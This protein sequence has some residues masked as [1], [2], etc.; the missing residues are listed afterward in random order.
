MHFQISRS[1]IHTD[2]PSHP[3]SLK[4]TASTLDG[5]MTDQKP[6]NLAA[7]GHASS[8][9][10]NAQMGRLASAVS[11]A[12]PFQSSIAKAITARRQKGQTIPKLVGILATPSPPSVAYAQWT[13]KAC[14]QVGIEFEIWQTWSENDRKENAMD[15]VEEQ[16][17]QQ[18]PNSD[19]EADVEDL[20]IAANSNES[21][22]GIMV[23][24]PIFGGR[25]DTYLQQIVDPRK[26]VEGLH[27]S[28]CF[29]MYHNIRW[30]NPSQLGGA[31]GTTIEASSG[32]ADKEESIPP[33]Y[34]KSILPCTPLA[35]VKCLESLGVYDKSL[36]Y[37]DR[38]Y[39]KTI[40][41]VNRSE[42]VGRPLAALLSNDG[43]QVYSVDLDSVQEFNKRA[44]HE[45]DRKPSKTVLKARE[46]NASHRLRPS[47]VVR[48]C[49][50]NLQ[51]C[52]AASDVVI[53]GV[54]AASF[55]IQ[56]EWVK[57]GTV[58]VNFSS[59]K[60]FEKDV[61][62]RASIHLPAIGKTT[63]AMLQRNLLRL[64]E[65]RELGLSES[66]NTVQDSGH[67]GSAPPPN[68]QS[69]E[70]NGGHQGSSNHNPLS[71]R[72]G[73]GSKNGFSGDRQKPNGN[74]ASQNHQDDVE[75]DEDGVQRSDQLKQQSV[76]RAQSSG[77][78]L[79]PP[80]PPPG[81]HQQSHYPSLPPHLGSTNALHLQ[82]ERA[83]TLSTMRPDRAQ[84][85]PNGPLRSLPQHGAQSNPNAWEWRSPS[86][87]PDGL[88]RS[89]ASA[90]SPPFG[91]MK[92]APSASEQSPLLFAP[93]G[94]QQGQIGSQQ[95]SSQGS[96]IPIQHR[97]SFR[98]SSISSPRSE[99]PVSP[100]I[101]DGLSVE[102]T[103]T[104]SNA[105]GGS[106]RM[107]WDSGTPHTPHDMMEMNLPLSAGS[108]NSG[109]ASNNMPSVLGRP[110][111]SE[112]MGY[113]HGHQPRYPHHHGDHPGFAHGPN[114]T[115][116]PTDEKVTLDM[117]GR[118]HPM[119]VYGSPYV[120]QMNH[121]GQLTSQQPSQMQ[122]RPMMIMP[123]DR[124]AHSRRR[125]RPPFSYSS[126]IAQA[127]ASA[128]EGRMTLREIYTWI[129]NAYPDLYSMEGSEGSGW[130][131]TV[132]HNLSLNKAFIKVART[133]QDIYDSCSSGLPNLS[134]QAR[135]KGGWWMLDPN[136][137]P[138]TIGATG[139]EEE[140]YMGAPDTIRTQ[141]RRRTN[142][143][144]ASVAS[145]DGMGSTGDLLSPVG[146]YPSAQLHPHGQGLPGA[147]SVLQMRGRAY[148]T[149]AAP[150]DEM[151]AGS[152]PSVLARPR[153]A[154]RSASNE[155]LNAQSD[156]GT[157]IAS[158][159]VGHIDD[160]DVA[161]HLIGRTRPRGYTTNSA[162]VNLKGGYPVHVNTQHQMHA[163][164]N[165]SLPTS[166]YGHGPQQLSRSP[167]MQGN[168]QLLSSSGP[169]SSARIG[170]S[171]AMHSVRSLGPAPNSGH[172]QLQEKQPLTPGQ[173]PSPS[174]YPINSPN[175]R[176]L[177]FDGEPGLP[178]AGQ[179]A[180]PAFYPAVRTGSGESVGHAS[181]HQRLSMPAP[182][183]LGGQK[184]NLAPPPITQK[185]R[186]GE[187]MRRQNSTGDQSNTSSDQSR[188]H[189]SATV[190]RES[191]GS[192]MSIT[193]LLS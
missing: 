56:T 163:H 94:N 188:E 55:K 109:Q 92:V 164:H 102:D 165:A 149:T 108:N 32:S 34:A 51:E 169:Q 26:D 123:Q 122:G 37:G 93:I 3:F 150:T 12:G 85:S 48:T 31:P 185:S 16:S 114:V 186:L 130:Q 30:I 181:P 53:S 156:R 75:M 153:T 147:P 116:T 135:G 59:E 62:T 42:V 79:P 184:M 131:N 4:Q 29:N 173:A 96:R 1:Y 86:T 170:A 58:T 87:R 43:A 24:Y 187:L 189:A 182:S 142:S 119:H 95:Q 25:Q 112:S 168:Q 104:S 35:V 71:G 178:F 121:N 23:Y 191:K 174:L 54:P 44:E 81:S 22:H 161:R 68:R 98:S 74:S 133:A 180:P 192:R 151:N 126:L 146:G 13:K 39:G 190:E 91:S 129:S 110:G 137:N 183:P 144:T 9:T 77:Q 14:E 10:D 152:L 177:R 171:P 167:A 176:K 100:L 60:N 20:I 138:A 63:I 125:R 90:Q 36:P 107:S 99:T 6:D 127:I 115:M 17:S 83:S 41:V 66:A 11:I 136:V 89:G 7:Q 134:Q 158:G 19:L 141:R 118:P 140:E 160:H 120:G 47:H 33:G 101:I 80:P 132:R 49:N 145:E 154:E 38:L 5:A 28:Y 88:A 172:Y 155:N 73:E 69:E 84:I 52:I 111:R 27:F 162:D 175:K 40:T 143:F 105:G 124:I 57:P 82:R 157:Q 8:S 113:P 70:G 64:V 117:D 61:R 159:V 97:S 106:Q 18:R 2:V 166:P 46:M 78:I 179:G 148:T 103:T 72:N 65:Y 67:S 45:S 139:K 21:I 128:P 50:M 193:G 15:G 76:G